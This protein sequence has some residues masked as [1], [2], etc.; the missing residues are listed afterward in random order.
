MGAAFDEL[1]AAL[2]SYFKKRVADDALAED[3]VQETFVRLIRAFGDGQAQPSHLRGLV[4]SIAKN[5]V[6]DVYRRRGVRG[7]GKGE[8]PDPD[9]LSGDEGPNADQAA[10]DALGGCLKAMVETLPDESKDA[11]IAH[12]LEG[13]RIAELAEAAGIGESGMK[14]RLQR[15]RGKVRAQF[16]KCCAVSFDAQGRAVDYFDPKPGCGPC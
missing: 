14:S 7:Y 13:T 3:L 8:A 5:L 6:I 11:L 2:L 1:S 9:A 12:D 16:E 15:A 4:F 10:R